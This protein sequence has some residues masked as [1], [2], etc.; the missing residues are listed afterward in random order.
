MSRTVLVT[1]ASGM[2][3]RAVV[4]HLSQSGWRVRAA[5]RRT[6][7]DLNG[8][9]VEHVLL[10][11]LER[12]FDWRPLVQGISAVAHIA[13]LAHAD[14]KWEPG[15]YQAINAEA[16]RS[17]AVAA[18]NEGVERLVFVSSV[19]AQTGPQ[20]RRVLT[21]E[22]DPQ[23]TDP[24]GRSKLLAEQFIAETLSA[25]ATD[26]VVLRPPAVYGEGAI[27]NMAKLERAARLRLPLGV[28]ALVGR[29]SLIGVGALASAIEHALVAKVCGRRVFLVAEPGPLTVPEIIAAMRQGLG[30]G[31]GIFRLPEPLL[32]AGL[33]VLGLNQLMDRLAGDLIVDTSAFEATG[34]QAREMAADG[35]ARF[36][37]THRK[38][39]IWVRAPAPSEH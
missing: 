5:A 27:A 11:D 32:R 28:G 21:E 15:L 4:R 26:W 3:G 34:W 23:P 33:A 29:R 16:T 36:M 30:R 13:G 39:S 14:G 12:P 17:L 18:R 8:P 10:G 7:S 24:Y 35:L 20:S 19:R 31:P 25:G 2:V 38:T 9:G 6:R 22:S 1:G 37:Q